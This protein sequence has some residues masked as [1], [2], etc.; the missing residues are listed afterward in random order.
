MS[1][2]EIVIPRGFEMGHYDD[3]F[4]GVTVLL[5]KKGAIGGC[6]Q[7][8]G[9]PGTR[10][11]DLLRNE[12]MMQKI[13]AVVLSGG[14]AYGLAASCGVMDWLKQHGYGYR[15]AG[16]LVPIVSGAVLFDLNQKEYH[17]DEYTV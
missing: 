15:T 10:E 1:K 14:S 17:Y 12:K 2:A 13:N 7:R 9:A 6:D 4:T 5:A 11:T 3:E 16:K 8:G